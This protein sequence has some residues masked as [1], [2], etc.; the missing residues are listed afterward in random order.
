MIVNDSMMSHNALVPVPLKRFLRTQHRRFML[1]RSI[2]R[3]VRDRNRDYLDRD[4]V[5]SL[6]YGWGNSGWSMQYE[7][8]QG[9][10]N[11]VRHTNRPILEC[12]S[13]LSTILMA[14]LAAGSGVRI[15]SLEHIPEW[16]DRVGAVLSRHGLHSARICRTVLRS[17][18]EFT[19]YELPKYIPDAFGLV[20][21]D[22]PPASTP[23]GRY[24]LLPII[25]SRLSP[26]AVILI[27]DVERSE[28]DKI[29]H[30]WAS[31]T[32]GSAQIEG[33]EKPYGILTMPGVA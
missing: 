29:L 11:H 33:S 17:Y 15:W 4:V 27:D 9:I 6:I 30:Q 25:R 21:C 23:G 1:E 31:M 3:L 28:E 22:G 18:G 7:Y 32:G 5:E 8:A 2:A 20:V 12:G 19:W 10:A 16:A 14:A 26:G 24:G 13:G